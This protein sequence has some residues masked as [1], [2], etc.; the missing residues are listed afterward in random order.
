M[1]EPQPVRLDVVHSS[2][3]DHIIHDQ[4]STFIEILRYALIGF[5]G[6][7]ALGWLAFFPL[8]LH[9][10]FAVLFTGLHPRAIT[11]D[12]K[13]LFLRK[14]LFRMWLGALVTGLLIFLVLFGGSFYAT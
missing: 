8:L 3:P 5:G 6:L 1:V 7:F 14:F 12:P 4:M 9:R 2:S 10:V 13:L 11:L